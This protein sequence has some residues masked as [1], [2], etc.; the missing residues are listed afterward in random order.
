MPF[1]VY[2]SSAGS[3]KTFTLVKEYLVLVLSRPDEYKNILAITFTNKATSEMKSRILMTLNYLAYYPEG[4]KAIEMHRELSKESVLLDVNIQKRAQDVLSR[5][6]HHYSEFNVSTIDSFVHRIVRS[7]AF[8]LNLPGNFLVSLDKDALMEEALSSMLDNLKEGE[9]LTRLLVSFIE[10][11]VEQEERYDISNSLKSIGSVLF[12]EHEYEKALSLQSLT[13]DDFLLIINKLNRLCRDFESRLK[14]IGDHFIAI[15]KEYNFTE[16]LAAYKASGYYGYL[17]SLSRGDFKSIR[18]GKRATEQLSSGKWFGAKV[19][20]P[21]QN[22]LSN[23]LTTLSGALFALLDSEADSYEICQLV[24][25]QIFETAV[26]A[27][28]GIAIQRVSKE[29]NQVHLSEFNRKIS[30]VVLNEPIPFV[31][32]RVGVKFR[33]FLLDEFQDTSLIQ[34]QNLLPLVHNALSSAETGRPSTCLVVGDEKQ[35]IYR[36]RGGEVEQFHSLPEIYNCPPLVWFKEA[37]AQLSDSYVEKTLN[38]NYRSLE[39][40]VTFNNRLFRAIVDGLSDEKISGFYKEL[41]QEVPK[42]REGGFVRIEVVTVPKEQSS[43]LRS[44]ATIKA[45]ESIRCML[46]SGWQANRIAVLCRTNEECSRISAGLFEASIPVMSTESLLVSSSQ[47]VSCLVSALLSLA[48][49]NEELYKRSF[50]VLKSILHSVDLASLDDLYD[51]S[52]LFYQRFFG[53]HPDEYYSLPLYDLVEQMIRDIIP[54]SSYNVYLQF[55]LDAV[56]EYQKG[57]NA[58]LSGFLSWWSEVSGK[59]SVFVPEGAEA[60]QVMT[61]HKAKGLDFD[62]IVM[63]YLLSLSRG[64]VKSVY[65]WIS[66]NFKGVEEL[67]VAR[68]KIK[69][70]LP[71]PVN[72][73]YIEEQRRQLLDDLNLLYVA[74]TRTCKRM[75]LFVS[76][77]DGSASMQG[78][79]SLLKIGLSNAFQFN[80]SN[81]IFEFGIDNINLVEQREKEESLSSVT[82]TIQPGWHD[83]VVIGRPSIVRLVDKASNALETG[84]RLHNILASVIRSSDFDRIVENELNHSQITPDEAEDLMRMFSKLMADPLIA[85]FFGDDGTVL[86]EATLV[87]PGGIRLRPDRVILYENHAIV[88]DY[89]TGE[90]HEEH[91][92]QVRNYMTALKDTGIPH[93]MGYLLYLSGTPLLQVV[94]L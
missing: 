18:P 24:L 60:V 79:T 91:H 69:D 45:V 88:V 86:T 7:F 71:E 62:V 1:L 44:E 50:L 53:R 20:I 38:V 28:I 47:E 84:L 66:P 41:E 81:G 93:V 55:F 76:S 80:E 31:Y 61:I 19:S 17:Q 92:V 12:D 68:V 90:L 16:D 37:E 40:I 54:I 13:V 35:S 11:R 89:K 9:T 33:H 87:I 94:K 43:E 4:K 27:N 32:S 3:G 6:L 72:S 51:S 15:S 46:N 5:I 23:E 22:Q 73:L 85:T 42:G 2:R 83:R 63:P 74:L 30:S 48:Y 57:E 52:S 70:G 67:N 59:K 21:G 36:W 49:P 77:V 25:A 39:Q 8:D 56:L 34:W 10:K 29:K 65:D 82:P 64:G 14:G 75:L 26:L 78:M 58:G